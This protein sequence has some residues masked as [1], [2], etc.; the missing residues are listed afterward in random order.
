[1]LKNITF[2]DFGKVFMLQFMDTGCKC[3]GGIILKYRTFRLKNYIAFIKA[4]I[5]KMNAD[6]AFRFCGIDYSFVDMMPVHAFSAKFWQQGRMNIQDTV[7][8]LLYDFF[9]NQ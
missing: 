9:R 3:I 6:T 5:H 1:M 4:F 7:G 2:N 8:V